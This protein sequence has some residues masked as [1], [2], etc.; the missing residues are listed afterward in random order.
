[1]PAA[2][3]LVG[4]GIYSETRRSA[5]KRVAQGAGP[6]LLG[7]ALDASFTTAGTIAGARHR[8]TLRG[9]AERAVALRAAAGSDMLDGE[10]AEVLALATRAAQRLDA[11]ETSLAGADL[12]EPDAATR[13]AVH[14]RDRLSAHILQ[15]TGRLDA[16]RVRVAVAQ[17]RSGSGPAADALDDL[18][19]EIAGLDEVAR[20]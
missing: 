9:V 10:L 6:R 5:T 8:D 1:M 3:G 17:V 13:E 12:R 2:L 14:A 7:P 19:A 16:M 15:L 18:R 20:L 11:L 4:H